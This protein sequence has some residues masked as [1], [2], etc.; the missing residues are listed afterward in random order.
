LRSKHGQ[1]FCDTITGK[2]VSHA[3]GVLQIKQGDL[4]NA[5]RAMVQ[6]RPGLG[7]LVA[8]VAQPIARA[9]DAGGSSLRDY[10]DSSGQTGHFQDAFRV[11][12]R[13]GQPCTGCGTPVRTIRQGNRSTFYCVNCQRR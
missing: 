7:D 12:G 3:D 10:V 5:Y 2:A 8:A 11:Y 4:F 6:P 13:D 9:I 1:G